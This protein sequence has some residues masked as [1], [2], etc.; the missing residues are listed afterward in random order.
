MRRRRD[1]LAARR[2]RPGGEAHWRVDGDVATSR[3]DVPRSVTEHSANTRRTWLGDACGAQRSGK[4]GASHTGRG[5]A[6]AGSPLG[7]PAR[8][9]TPGGVG[10]GEERREPARAGQGRLGCEALKAWRF[11]L[12]TLRAIVQ[13]GRRRRGRGSGEVWG[14]GE[15][16]STDTTVWCSPPARV[17]HA[18]GGER[19]GSRGCIGN[20]QRCTENEG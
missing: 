8:V 4:G 11:A 17:V 9:R 1:T 13:H 2:S 15:G 19:G 7:Q 5:P 16:Y 10:W 18:R 12:Y 3:R 20:R 14:G 6:R